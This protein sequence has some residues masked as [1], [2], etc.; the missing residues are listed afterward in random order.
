MNFIWPALL[1][2]LVL[3]PLLGSVYLRMQRRRREILVRYGSLGLIQEAGGKGIDSGR[4]I[5][6]ILFLVGLTILFFSLA[7]PEMVIGLPKVEGVVIL[8]FDVSGSMAATD[9]QPTRL[10]AAKSVAVEFVNRQPSTVQVGVVEFSESGFSIV[11]P[12]SDREAILQ[13]IGRLKIQ[14]GTSLANG[15]LVSLNTIANT[16][17]R[18][19]IENT[20]Q[21]DIPIQGTPLPATIP[22][23]QP[24]S[25][26]D[27]SAVIVLLT[28]GENN[29][30]PDPMV[31]V[32][33]AAERGI[34]IHTIAIGSPQGTV[35]TVNGFSIFTQV[36]EQLLKNIAETTG[37]QY[38]NAQNVDDLRNIYKSIE[39]Q[40]QVRPEETE[41]TSLLAGISILIFLI[42]GGFSL[43]WFNRVP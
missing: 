23:S 5:P 30:S 35:V 28:D 1:W 34:R 4:H 22:S 7:R 16:E 31:A 40:L 29:A 14:K 42:G 11:V 36:N 24:A 6:M 19:E 26:G 12:S 43:F 37:G 21:I 17:G 18:A 39:P 8:A 13:A 10:D 41:I 3:I 2:S 20:D 15:I 33:A 38:F 25:A 9:L 32:R 27:N